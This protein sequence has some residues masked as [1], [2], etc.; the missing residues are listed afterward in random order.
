[1]AACAEHYLHDCFF[2]CGLTTPPHKMGGLLQEN[3]LVAC[4]VNKK[5]CKTQVQW[6]GNSCHA[7]FT[8]VQQLRGQCEVKLYG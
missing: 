4:H 3:K 8:A 1:M 2:T 5:M 6:Q 7:Q